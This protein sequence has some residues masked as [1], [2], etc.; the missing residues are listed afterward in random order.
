MAGAGRLLDPRDLHLTLCFLGAVDQRRRGLLEQRL[1]ALSPP[2]L[3]L[4]FDR[5]EYWR[6]SKLLA[7]CG[8]DG[9]ASP[10]AAW[11]ATL[12]STARA[13]GIEPGGGVF[14][15]HVT[16]ARSVRPADVGAG[17]AVVVL[18]L[19]QPIEWVT[20]RLHLAESVEAPAVVEPPPLRYRILSTWGV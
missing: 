15:A 16:L 18:P 7:L 10:I 8:A 5:V 1:A 4:S 2:S 12:A 14:R 9:S 17:G 20:P 13:V 19:P 3:R 11:A 6:H